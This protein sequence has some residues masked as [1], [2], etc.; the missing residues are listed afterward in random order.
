M[1]KYESI[2]TNA[3]TKMATELPPDVYSALEK[4]CEEETKE[5]AN[6]LLKTI[7]QSIKISSKEKL[8][9]CQDTGLISVY[10]SGKY[11]KDYLLIK[12]GLERA[13]SK[14][15]ESGVL[16]PTIVS[17]IKREPVIGNVGMSEPEVYLDFEGENSI[18]LMMRGAGAENYST[19][20][21]LL[22][23]TN[24][25]EI[26]KIILEQ[27]LEADGRICPPSIVGVAIGGS[28]ISAIL[29]SRTALFSKIG[30]RSKVN[31]VAEWELKLLRAINS[32]NIGSMGL[33]G[34]YTVLDVKIRLLGTHI[35]M[36][37][38]AITFGCW[39]LRRIQIKKVG[40]IDEIV[41]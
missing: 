14:L 22:P 30:E 26:S 11:V 36:L 24:P 34:V 1:N 16:R 17:P 6:N 33:G 28:P 38:L 19:L 39:A 10:I 37:P 35:A 18:K 23:S 12:E 7:I 20:K 15:T 21:M 5:V 25:H 3:I 13:I 40:N 9:I 27:V 32:L 31:E 8:P 29:S 41:W 2:L 4:A